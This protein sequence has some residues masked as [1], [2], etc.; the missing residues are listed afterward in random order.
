MSPAI[1]IRLIIQGRQ[2]KRWDCRYFRYSII[3]PISFLVW[4]RMSG[5]QRKR[6]LVFLLTGPG[7]ERMEQSG[8]EK[9]FWRI[10]ILLNAGAVLSHLLRPVEML[11]LKKD[12]ELQFLFLERFTERKSLFR[13]LK[14]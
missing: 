11:L 12:G 10:M 6:L 5:Q 9:S 8:E 2:Q 1:C 14:H 4:Q 3:T 13:L 7:T